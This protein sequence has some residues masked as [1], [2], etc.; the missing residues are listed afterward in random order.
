V[1][2]MTR[3][4][5]TAVQRASSRAILAEGSSW[6][7]NLEVDLTRT[8]PWTNPGRFGWNGGF[9]TAANVDPVAD[10]TIVFFSQRMLESPAP[11]ATFTDLWRAV[12]A[13]VGAG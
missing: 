11:P 3:D 4:R 13:E 9:G 7:L 10:L 8:E 2:I 1:E 5:L 12:Y 6:G